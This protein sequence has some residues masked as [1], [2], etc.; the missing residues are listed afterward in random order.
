[1]LEP[2]VVSLSVTVCAV[3]KLPPPGLNVGVATVPTPPPAPDVNTWNSNSEYPNAVPRAVPSIRMK[4]PVPFTLSVCTP[5]VPVVVLKMVVQVAPSGEVWIWNALANAASQ[6][7]TTWH[8]VIDEPRSTCND[9]GSL[10]A[11]DQ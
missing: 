4:R 2:G 7:S 6:F 3:V 9:C 1:M 5:P 10:K 11:L 8:T